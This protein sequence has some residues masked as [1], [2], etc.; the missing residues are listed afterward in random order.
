MVYD[1][2]TLLLN[3]TYWYVPFFL[4]VKLHIYGSICNK[5]WEKRLKNSQIFSSFEYAHITFLVDIYI[6][7]KYELLCTEI[8]YT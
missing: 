6:Y 2:V 4:C 1:Y 8:M 3:S 7:I 5:D